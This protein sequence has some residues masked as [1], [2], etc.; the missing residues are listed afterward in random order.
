MEIYDYVVVGA[1]SAGCVMARR[2]SDGPNVSVLLLEAGGASDGFWNR[3]PAGVARFH[4]SERYNWNYVTE[5]VPALGDRKLYFPAGK[6]LGGSSAINGMVYIRGDRRDFDHWAQL[7]NSGWGWDDVLPYFKRSE[8]NERG[9]SQIHGADGPLSVSNPAILHPTVDDF[10]EASQACGLTRRDDLAAGDLEGAGPVQFTIRNGERESSY[11]AFIKPVRHRSNLRVE[12]GAQVSKILFKD[13]A[14]V[15]VELAQN[16]HVRRVFARREII[17]SAGAVRSPHLL[18]LSGVGDGEKLR[19]KGISAVVHLPGVGENLQDHYMVRVQAET[20]R[21]SSYNRDLRGWRKYLQGAGYLLTKGGYLALGTSSAAAFL[22]SRPSVEYADIEISFR[23]MT[24]T[25]DPTGRVEV[26]S[27]DAI[28][29]SVYRVRPASRGYI[30][31]ESADPLV[32]PLVQPNYLAESEDV[33]ATVEGIKAFR[34]ILAT[35]PLSSKVRGEIAPGSAIATDDDLS[36]YVRSQG[37]SVFHPAG[38]CKMGSDPMAVV[39]NQLRVRG[40]ERLRVVDA[41]IMPVVTSGNTNA[42]TI[43]IG[44][45][46]ADL[47]KAS[48][49]SALP[50]ETFRSFEHSPSLTE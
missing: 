25:T 38:T 34:R 27:Y 6:A 50:D 42:P 3:T 32:P 24:F 28:S 48:A 26:D 47:V 18:M 45:K 20:V 37:G 11:Y 21:E 40:V 35:H 12:V 14:A 31:L 17:L 22:K 1:G 41:S 33:D 43:M 46:A 9:G 15:G 30:G 16:A 13:R 8:S 5:P 29:G 4:K 49:V 44:E 7:G 19:Q 39:D 10:I 36:D 2:L 23:P